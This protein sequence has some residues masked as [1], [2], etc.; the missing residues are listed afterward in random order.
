MKRPTMFLWFG[1]VAIVAAVAIAVW[2][3]RPTPLHGDAH[4][5]AGS[6]AAQ[7]AAA[8]TEAD[9][10]WKEVHSFDRGQR[11]DAKLTAIE[12]SLTHAES[13][14]ASGRYLDAV[15]VYRGLGP[16]MNDVRTAEQGRRGAIQ[17]R[18]AAEKARQV[19][20]SFAACAALEKT[21]ARGVQAD[22]DATREFEAAEFAAAR[23]HWEAATDEFTQAQTSAARAMESVTRMK[24]AFEKELDGYDVATL[25][26]VETFDKAFRGLQDEAASAVEKGLLRRAAEKY[27]KALRL[28][29]DGNPLQERLKAPLTDNVSG[30]EF[31]DILVSLRTHGLP[32]LVDWEALAKKKVTPERV[33]AVESKEVP[34]GEYLRSALADL[35]SDAHFVVRK[36]RLV[37]ITT[38]QRFQRGWHHLESGLGQRFRPKGEVPV[39]AWQGLKGAD[40]RNQTLQE[41]AENLA[42]RMGV[43]RTHMKWDAIE[44]V[45]VDKNLKVPALSDLNGIAAVDALWAILIV[46]DGRLDFVVDGDVL[47]ISTADELG[48][49]ALR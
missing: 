29:A 5:R 49:S 23:K 43:G 25:A 44:K 12:T 4:P 38:K 9:A 1:G 39:A 2:T 26:R 19:D 24:R 20:A 30:F 14:A 27:E 31:Q 45:G 35:S 41:A 28:L 47:T 21:W 6:P 7:F 18:T 37:L 16:R 36:G 22:T 40:F 8:K 10:I 13:L 15:G 34:A 32:L 42:K 33:V 48:T 11:F 46:V 17:A 3:L